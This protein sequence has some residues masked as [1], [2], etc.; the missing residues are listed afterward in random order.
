MAH[1]LAPHRRQIGLALNIETIF[2][3]DA[4]AKANHMSRNEVAEKIL[5]E[6][7]CEVELDKLAKAKVQ[8]EII[9]NK[10]KRKG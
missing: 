1:M 8:A 4:K 10:A 2:K 5:S 3:L 7:L 6:A 9:I